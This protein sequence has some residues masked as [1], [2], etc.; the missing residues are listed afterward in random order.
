MAGSGHRYLGRVDD[1]L[2]LCRRLK[3]IVDTGELTHLSTPG[4]G[5]EAFDIARLA[6]LDRR[7]DIDLDEVLAEPTDKVARLPIRR[8]KRGNDEDAVLLELTC[9]ISDPFDVLVALPSRKAGAGK[10]ISHGVAIQALDFEAASAQCLRHPV[11]NSALAG[12]REP[13]EPNHAGLDRLPT[14]AEPIPQPLVQPIQTNLR[15]E[16]EHSDG[17][18]QR[19]TSGKDEDQ[20]RRRYRSE[21]APRKRLHDRTGLGFL[22][23]VCGGRD[24]STGD[25]A[26]HCRWP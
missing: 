13:C 9:E 3:R 16:L 14:E 26:R 7:R 12:S 22:I 23:H 17:K 24:R 18:R 6:D 5:I 2:R 15:D 10:E 25:T 1:Q 19:Q 20:Q 21:K 4:L 11:S 8:H